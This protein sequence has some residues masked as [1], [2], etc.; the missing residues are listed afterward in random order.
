MSL[1]RL[2]RALARAGVASRRKAEDLIRAGR[3]QIDGQTA[4]IGM[5]VDPDAQRITV[6]GRAVRGP[7]TTT[8]LALNK[9][10]GYVVSRSDPEGRRTVFD[11]LPKVPGLTYVG[12]L[13]VMTSGL[14]LLTTDG[15]AAH[16]L[17]HPRFA[18]PRSYWLGV[19]GADAAAVR[20]ALA[21]R[22]V[23]DGRPVRIEQCRVRPAGRAVEVELTLAEGRY[24]I[25]RRVA[26]HLGL[27]VEWLHRVA[28]GPVRLGRLAEGKWRTLTAREIGA[29]ER[30]HGAD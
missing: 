28:Y 13:D 16:R 27:K 2:Q 15:A 24:R 30:R 26:E 8:W 11:L 6:D 5:S 4:T 14:L 17:M 7:T 9:P 3:V 19:H 1:M 12:R 21:A 20:A 25:V 22:I 10:I 29:I 18:V 23:L